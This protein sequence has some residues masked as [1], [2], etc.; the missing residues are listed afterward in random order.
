MAQAQVAVRVS[1]HAAL[2]PRLHQGAVAGQ[3]SLRER[4]R[5]RED[6]CADCGADVGCG[7]LEVLAGV[8]GHDP[9]APERGDTQA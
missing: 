1:G 9:E 4:L 8:A 2:G 6:G 3:G 5:S 7:L